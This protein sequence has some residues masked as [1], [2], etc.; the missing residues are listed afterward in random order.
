MTVLPPPSFKPL[1]MADAG[2]YIGANGPYYWQR[3]DDGRVLYGFVGDARHANP[4]G[5]LHGGAIIGF[6][7]TVIGRLIV[8]ETGRNCATIAL[9][10]RFVAPAPIGSW[11]EARI[12]L[13][14]TTAS[15]AFVD[16]QVTADG[17][18]VV[19]ASA[20]FRLF[21]GSARPTPASA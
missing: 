14:K 1:R 9:D 10:T 13:S 17:Q 20:I 8:H 15:M 12:Q 5:V 6:L 21:S 4:N 11:I 7:D 19:T 2:G 3:S 16:A 18:L